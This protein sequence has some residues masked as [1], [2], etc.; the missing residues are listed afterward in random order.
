[1]TEDSVIHPGNE[2]VVRL[3]E[4][5]APPPTPTPKLTHTIRT[6][7]SLWVIAALYDLTLD[8]LMELNNLTTDS[9][10]RP[11]EEL[12]IRLPTPTPPPTE[13]P[14]PAPRTTPTTA[15]AAQSSPSPATA[16][17]RQR[18][19]PVST[20]DSEALAR[21]DDGSAGTTTAIVALVGLGIL[22]AAAVIIVR[23]QRT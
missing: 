23:R 5:Q 11:G 6:G 8:Q 14:T 2:V 7:Q 12:L 18:L 9:V 3:A 1:M 16:E 17:V 22:A 15:L 20:P 21:Q 4:G 10:I 19:T 13:T